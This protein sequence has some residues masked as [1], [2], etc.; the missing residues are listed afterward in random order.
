MA[1]YPRM[2]EVL[3]RSEAATWQLRE[4]KE[5]AHRRRNLGV[6]SFAMGKVARF[7]SSLWKR[8]S[9]AWVT[10]GQQAAVSRDG[11]GGFGLRGDSE[12]R[13]GK[14]GGVEA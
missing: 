2:E 12:W 4:G 13:L 3:G 7:S 14:R 10:A 9:A 6:V 8:G 11:G 5:E 1:V